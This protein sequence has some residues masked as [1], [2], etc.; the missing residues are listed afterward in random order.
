MKLVV[1]Q[2]FQ[3]L[4]HNDV[5]TISY[6]K[7]NFRFEIRFDFRFDLRFEIFAPMLNFNS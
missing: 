1:L 5:L 2:N 6:R 7:Y 3:I 4:R